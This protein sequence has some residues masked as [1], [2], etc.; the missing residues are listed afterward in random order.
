[1]QNTEINAL[2]CWLR[3]GH[4]EKSTRTSWKT[5]LVTARWG[6]QDIYVYS[7]WQES[8][9]YSIRTGICYWLVTV[10]CF[11]LSISKW[12]ST[13]TTNTQLYVWHNCMCQDLRSWTG[14]WMP[15]MKEGL[16]CLIQWV[17]GFIFFKRMRWVCRNTWEGNR[18]WK[19]LLVVTQ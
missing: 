5:E 19:M 4:R 3:C 2:Q 7:S 1:M 9:C 17:G 18:L 8:F 14:S 10:T 6:T 12:R 16:Y 15:Q 13:V 11:I